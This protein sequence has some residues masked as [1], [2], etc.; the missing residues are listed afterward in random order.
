[1][2]QR[3]I[4]L[5]GNKRFLMTAITQIMAIN[6]LL[7]DRDLGTVVGQPLNQFSESKRVTHKPQ[8]NLVFL[9]DQANVAAS[10][11][12]ITAE[13]SFRLMNESES[14]ITPISALAL[15]NRI[16]SVFGGTTAYQWKKGRE[17]WGYIEPARGYHL[18]IYAWNEAEAK[19]VIGKILQVQNHTP[20]WSEYLKDWAKRDSM[21]NTPII[22]PTDL[23]YGQNRRRPRKLPVGFVRFIR[24]TLVLDGLQNPIQ[25]V[26]L[27]GLKRTAL[28]RG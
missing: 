11:Q 27:T 10:Y 1:M 3:P 21:V 23:I 9:E 28:V 5:K 20:N 4:I 22:P 14:T 6:Q 2:S 13:L 8:V 18:H 24:A 7:G 12:A 19:D 25:L 16:K 26:D 17:L 15:A